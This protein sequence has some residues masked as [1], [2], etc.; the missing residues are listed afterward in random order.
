MK[1]SVWHLG[2]CKIS[3]SAARCLQTALWGCSCRFFPVKI[4]KYLGVL[5][6]KTTKCIPWPLSLLRYG[7]SRLELLRE[8]IKDLRGELVY[9]TRLFS[10]KTLRE[11]DTI[12]LDNWICWG[13]YWYN[14]FKQPKLNNTWVTGTRFTLKRNSF[15]FLLKWQWR[16]TFLCGT[17]IAEV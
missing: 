9:K 5:M 4:I 10:A 11:G 3:Y 15:H 13:R 14:L 1:S 16:I 8:E 12:A 6:N 17:C 7:E 2:K